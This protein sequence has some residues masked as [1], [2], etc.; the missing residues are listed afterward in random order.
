[1]AS[2]SLSPSLPRSLALLV[3][4][5]I[6]IIFIYFLLRAIVMAVKAQSSEFPLGLRLAPLF[7]KAL[8]LPAPLHLLPTISP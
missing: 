5:F 7:T 1:M 3:Q 8:S 2:S 4:L 6:T